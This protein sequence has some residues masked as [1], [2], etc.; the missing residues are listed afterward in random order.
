MDLAH[1]KWALLPHQKGCETVDFSRLLQ[2]L[3]VSK[4]TETM[5]GVSL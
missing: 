1:Q 2:V 4:G 5:K 3:L